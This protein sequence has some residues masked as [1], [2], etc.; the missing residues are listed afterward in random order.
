[1]KKIGSLFYKPKQQERALKPKRW[2][3]FS[4]FWKAIKKTCMVI[5]AMVLFSTLLS[6]ILITSMAKKPVAKLSD[7]MILY[8]DLEDG[9]SETQSKPSLLEPFPF[10]Q[11]TLRHVIN[12]IHK[13]KDDGRVKGLVFSLKGA[14]INV[15][16]IQELRSAIID[17][18]TSG[19]FT[20]V[21]SSS[22]MDAMG[23]LSQYYLASTFDEI[24]M[25]PIGMMSISGMNM[26]MPFAKNALDKLGVSA[27]FYQREEYKSA[28]ENL[29]NTDISPANREALQ[30]MLDSLSINMVN[31]IA[32]ARNIPATTL[33]SYVDTGILTGKEALQNKLIDRL[34]YG[35][36][37]LSEARKSISGDPDDEGVE[38]VALESYMGATRGKKIG[39]M[40]KTL[41]AKNN[42]AL[43]QISGTIVDSDNGGNAGADK[44][45]GA[46]YQAYND[47]NIKAII[48]RVDSPGG[49]PTASETI[50]RGIVKAKEKGKKIIVSMGP[51]AA[52]GGYWVAT[53][54]DMI[55]ANAGTITG[56]IGVVMGKFEASELFNKLGVNWQ[57]PKF[58]DNADIWAMHNRFDGAGDARMN[59]L[60]DSTYDAF[61]ERVSKGRGMTLE[62]ARAVAKGRPWTGLQAKERNLVDEIGGLNEAFDKTA[63]MLGAENRHDLNIIK[64]PRELN[65]VERV[66]ELLGQKVSIGQFMKTMFK[67]DV[68][69]SKWIQAHFN[70]QDVLR[71]GNKTSVY[72]P[73]LELMR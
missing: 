22:Y 1:M 23:G 70:Q 51:V 7:D 52:S 39:N 3:V 18:K 53:D 33:K 55:V 38:L 40:P 72:N 46:I 71:N 9:I 5:G 73:E 36:V 62:E 24:W 32:A 6:V 21:Y 45:S 57:G 27:Q 49:S 17:F 19:K 16:H 43:I 63:V 37:L 58:G 2:N 14:P 59:V 4:I 10:T 67:E 42:V 48:L 69:M 56:S 61:I 26:E 13:A 30:T 41:N 20:K 66:L 8:F 60:I 12:T 44:I 28:M 35:D 25:Q 11:P 68:T 50:R 64:M 54:A 65:N 29:T 31:E 15:A 47:E 34:D